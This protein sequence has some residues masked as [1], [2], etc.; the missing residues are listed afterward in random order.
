[1]KNFSNIFTFI[2]ANIIFSLLKFTNSLYVKD[3]K[4]PEVQLNNF[5][6]GSCFNGFGSKNRLRFDIF[7]KISIKNPD[8]FVWLG[9]VAY[10]DNVDHHLLLGT[11]P[12]YNE[13]KLKTKYDETFYEKNYENFRKE[14]PVIGIW[15]DHDYSYNNAK[16]D[17]PYKHQVKQ[18]FLDFLETPKDSIRRRPEDQGIYTSYS[19]G[20]DHKSVKV[21]LL[22]LRYEQTLRG[23]NE[24]MMS[25]EQWQWL[26]NELTNSD[27][28][29]TFITSGIQLLPD[30][31]NSFIEKWYQK[32]RERFFNLIGKTKKSGVIVLSGDVHIGQ[33]M[34]TFCIHPS[35]YYKFIINKQY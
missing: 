16:G 7:E 27:E 20:K 3:G 30:N 31:R 33:L 1:M 4:H 15:D 13:K 10:L 2:L 24:N 29:F 34:K 9:D 11:V 25:E 21:I 5:A 6:F 12:A 22:D 26:E 28:T 35:K 23:E 18:L 19:F 17:S 14:K 8:L 32:S